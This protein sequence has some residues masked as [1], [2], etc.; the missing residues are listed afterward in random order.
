MASKYLRDPVHG[1]IGFDKDREKL[2]I[3]LIN[4]REFQRL[5]ADHP[6]ATCSEW[7]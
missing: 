2:V 1:S 5:R 7:T 4:T 6:S 3:D